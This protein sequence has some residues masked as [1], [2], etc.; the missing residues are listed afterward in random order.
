VLVNTEGGRFSQA[1]QQQRH[2]RSAQGGTCKRRRR[3][4][5]TTSQSFTRQT[6]RITQG[7]SPPAAKAGAEL[8]PDDGRVRWGEE[9]KRAYRLADNQ[10]TLCGSWDVRN[11]MQR[12]CSGRD[13]LTPTG[14]INAITSPPATPQGQHLQNAVYI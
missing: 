1:V 2:K 14:T 6:Q 9:E 12:R 7:C 8:D 5:R 3:P 13:G 11:Q 10:L 4:L